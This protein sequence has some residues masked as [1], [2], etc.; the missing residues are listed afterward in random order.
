MSRSHLSYARTR[1]IMNYLRRSYMQGRTWS[2]YFSVFHLSLALRVSQWYNH[3]DI[4]SSSGVLRSSGASHSNSSYV[5][6]IQP[7]ILASIA[8]L[9]TNAN[10]QQLGAWRIHPIWGT[11]CLLNHNTELASTVYIWTADTVFRT[12]SRHAL[13][14]ILLDRLLLCCPIFPL[15]H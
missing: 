14:C 13:N 8:Y 6:F 4:L 9:D 12:L 5:G 7:P 10:I 11:W 2:T 15:F 3:V 1:G